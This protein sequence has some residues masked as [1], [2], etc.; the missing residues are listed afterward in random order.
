MSKS[1]FLFY[2]YDKKGECNPLPVRARDLDDAW[3]V[4]ERRYGLETQVDCVVRQGE[5]YVTVDEDTYDV[6]YSEE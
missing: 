5:Q 2:A 4:F 6:Q 1:V 3:G